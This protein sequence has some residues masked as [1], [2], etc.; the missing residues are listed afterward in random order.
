M[1]VVM[2]AGQ[3]DPFA[4]FWYEMNV[5]LVESGAIGPSGFEDDTYEIDPYGMMPPAAPPAPLKVNTAI[6]AAPCLSSP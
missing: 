5:G 1:D 6:E 3:P 2:R 4:S